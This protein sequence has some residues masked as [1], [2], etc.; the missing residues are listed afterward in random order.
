MRFWAFWVFNTFRFRI[1]CSI[2]RCWS[3]T[4]YSIFMG[5]KCHFKICKHCISFCQTCA[6]AHV[7]HYSRRFRKTLLFDSAFITGKIAQVRCHSAS[8][9][10][11]KSHSILQIPIFSVVVSKLNLV[12]NLHVIVFIHCILP[13][14]SCKKITYSV[15]WVES[16][17]LRRS[18]PSYS[19]KTFRHFF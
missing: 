2:R 12:I 3:L 13:P 16:Q 11:K 10:G 8:I 14:L 17:D 6:S 1:L 15:P 4:D 5:W 7:Q 9:I 19:V 18:L